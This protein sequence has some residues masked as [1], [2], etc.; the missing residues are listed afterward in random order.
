MDLAGCDAERLE[1]EDGL[2]HVL[3][4]VQPRGTRLVGRIALVF[5]ERVHVCHQ[6][7]VDG[8]VSSRKVTSSVVPTMLEPAP[9]SVMSTMS[10]PASSEG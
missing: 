5:E 6:E 3:L 10:E 7:E 2:R 4:G 8:V 9:S 1:E